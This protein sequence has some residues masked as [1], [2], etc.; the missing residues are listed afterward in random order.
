MTRLNFASDYTQGAH[1]AILKALADTN[2]ETSA[3]YGT[4]KYCEAARRKIRAA[5]GCEKVAV[6]FVSGGTQANLTVL[7]ALLRPWEGV[8][9]ADTGHIG[10]HEAGAIE[11][12]GHKVLTV[13]HKNG[14]LTADAAEAF[15]KNYFGDA[16][17]EHMVCPGAI[18]ISQPTE[19]GTLYTLKELTALRK[20]CDE[21]GLKLYLDGA[22]LAYALGSEQNDVTLPDLARLCDVFYI[23]GTKCGALLGEAIVIPDPALL[24]RFFTQMKQHGAL[25]AKGRV[26]GLQFDA[27]FTDGLYLSLGKNA[28]QRAK[29]MVNLFTAHGYKEFCPRETNQ[30]FLLL[31]DGAY[32]ALSE[33]IVM[34]FWEKPDDAH[35]AVRIAASWATTAEELQ[36]LNKALTNR[37]Q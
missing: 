5:C 11:L 33:R 21:F 30:V 23:G 27:L 31:E 6:W 14:K 12:T 35:T 16:N 32:A 37:E 36:A 22:R 26:L 20:V 24:P 3:G 15:A 19:Y 17:R 13:P 9:S 2:F 4:D 8:L 25:L 34:S 7:D 28:V 29:E 10:G 18:Y 1:P